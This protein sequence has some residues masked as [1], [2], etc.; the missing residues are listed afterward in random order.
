MFCPFTGKSQK[1]CASFKAQSNDGTAVF[2][3]I[4]KIDLESIGGKCP[5]TCKKITSKNECSE[6][7]DDLLEAFEA[8]AKYIVENVKHSN[9]VRYLDVNCVIMDESLIVHLVQEYIEGAS[10]KDLYGQDVLPTLAP[11]AE[12]LLKSISYL[13]SMDPKIVHG[14]ISDASIFLGKSAVY[15]VADYHLVPYLMYLQDKHSM[16]TTTDFEAL[17]TLIASKNRIVQFFA[18]DFVEQCRSSQSTCWDL[19]S[20]VF[21]SN[22]HIGEANT[23]YNGPFLNHFE[24]EEIL[25]SG[26]YGNV[27]KA[28]HPNGQESFALKLIEL[29]R[30][31]KGQYGKVKREVELIS[32]VSHENVVKYITSWEQS[33]NITELGLSQEESDS[34]SA[35]ELVLRHFNFNLLFVQCFFKST[36][37]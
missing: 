4:W 35:D 26:S 2:I 22:A 17:G 27:V 23:I 14:Y 20:H 31:S 3:T 13:H 34:S 12:M 10:V 9:L 7:D 37:F 15:R 29:P 18:N 24:I 32:Q 36:I 25:G 5:I 19:L 21:L 16:N 30:G 6:H 1:G 28:K 11:I 8:R 33:V